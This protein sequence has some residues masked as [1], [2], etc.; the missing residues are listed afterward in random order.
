MTTEI[1]N[2]PIQNIGLC[3]N[4]F[5]NVLCS[6]LAERHDLFIEYN[7]EQGKVMDKM[8]DIF[9]Q[10]GIHLF[11]GKNKYNK[12]IVL[13][14]NDYMNL[15]N[16]NGNIDFNIVIDAGMYYQNSSTSMILYNY[17]NEEKNKN[18]IINANKFRD[19]YN[20]NN[21]LFIHIRLGDITNNFSV[22]PIYFEK[23]IESTLCDNIF[24][25]SDSPTHDICVNLCSKYP[26]CS[27]VYYN[28][29]ESIHFG[30]TCK[31]V[32]LSTGT[33]SCIIGYFSFFSNVSYPEQD[34]NKMWHGDIF[35]IPTWKKI[36][37]L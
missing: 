22:C 37:Y 9:Y 28:E 6:I 1:N 30:S 8:L 19:R 3:N 36:D 4:I 33:F 32:A 11:F 20:N 5:R 29:V 7:F 35:V 18:N 13:Q 2:Q 10:L 15:Y 31:H 24:I 21:D 23:I 26:N 12:Q 17:F 25:A 27:I 34:K 16:F 14:E